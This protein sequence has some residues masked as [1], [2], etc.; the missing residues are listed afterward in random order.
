MHIAI[1]IGVAVVLTLGLVLVAGTTPFVGIPVLIVA[2]AIAAMFAGAVR[3]ASE[4]R[5]ESDAPSSREAS[6]EPVID[7]SERTP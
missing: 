2:V 5:L 6:Y 4:R 7:P 1:A 3:R